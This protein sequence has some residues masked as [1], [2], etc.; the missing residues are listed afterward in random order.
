MADKPRAGPA[1]AAQMATV[2]VTSVTM[3]VGWIVFTVNQNQ[4]SIVA[5][6]QRLEAI[7]ER[8]DMRAGHVD[9]ELSSISKKLDSLTDILIGEIKI[10]SVAKVSED[11]NKDAGG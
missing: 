4:I 10:Q 1:W 7:S 2:I 6:D 9:D 3:M 11:D 8:S 5:I